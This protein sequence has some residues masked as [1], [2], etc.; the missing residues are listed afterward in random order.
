MQISSDFSDL[1]RALNDAEA[2]YLVVG[3]YALNYYARPRA[4]ADFDVWVDRAPSNAARVFRALA[5]YGAPLDRLTIDDLTSDDLIFQI[6]VSPIRID[7]MTDVSGL[8]F[9]DAWRNRVEDV[10]DGV[11]VAFIGRAD[12]ITNKLA[13]GRTK[14]RA[15]VERLQRDQ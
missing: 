7:M 6:G 14:D 11:R 8:D 15:D 1:L 3:A 5:Q 10:L 13:T 4:T 2:K 9:A 12:L